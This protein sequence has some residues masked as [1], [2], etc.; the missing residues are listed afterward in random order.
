MVWAIICFAVSCHLSFCQTETGQKPLPAN[1]EVKLQAGGLHGGRYGFYVACTAAGGVCQDGYRD[2]ESATVPTGSPEMTIYPGKYTAAMWSI[3]DPL[4]YGAQFAGAFKVARAAESCLSFTQFPNAWVS[5]QA[6]YTY[7]HAF[8]LD[9]TAQV[10]A[11]PGPGEHTGTCWA[12]G[13]TVPT[14]FESQFFTHSGR[15]EKVPGSRIGFGQN[16]CPCQSRRGSSLLMRH[17]STGLPF[18]HNGI[19]LSP[20]QHAPAHFAVPG[21][22][23]CGP[24][25]KSVAAHM[26]SGIHTAFLICNEIGS[27]WQI[28]LFVFSLVVGACRS[29]G[30]MLHPRDNDDPGLLQGDCRGRR[31]G[32]DG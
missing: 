12:A 21:C 28:G 26:D 24:Q 5:G 17:W 23:L 13:R 20:P 32:W 29:H 30:A 9:K 27:Q 3:P 10:C 4:F 8:W 22:L 2:T 15:L 16:V 7:Q 11:L 19:L 1:F 31:G 18:P 14:V 6:S 25:M